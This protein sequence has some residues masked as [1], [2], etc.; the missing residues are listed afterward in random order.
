MVG[1]CRKDWGEVDGVRPER[2]DVVHVCGNTVQVAAVELVGRLW[3]TPDH[4]VVPGLRDGPGGRRSVHRLGEPVRKD[5]VDDCV[6]GPRRWRWVRGD[7]EV[8]RIGDVV[9][10]KPGAVEPLVAAGDAVEQPSVVHDRVLD[11]QVGSQPPIPFVLA[12]DSRGDQIL[13][14]VDI[15]AKQ[16]LRDATRARHT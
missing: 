2:H 13:F 16:G 4:G 11:R 3:S 15:H 7:P 6:L 5:L 14:T 8:G 10:M 1:T 12:I 9:G